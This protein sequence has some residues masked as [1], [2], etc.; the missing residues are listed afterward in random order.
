MYITLI[1]CLLHEN[2]S[3]KQAGVAMLIWDIVDF[4]AN[5]ITRDKKGTL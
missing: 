1:F 2:I 5:K 4:R 3:Q